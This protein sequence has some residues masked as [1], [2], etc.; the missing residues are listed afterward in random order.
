MTLVRMN[1]K[2]YS[3]H[4]EAESS[5]LEHQGIYKRLS[6][7]APVQDV[8]E[9]G[10]GAGLATQH[11]ATNRRV[12]SIDNNMH[13]IGS[14]KNLLEGAGIDANIIHADFFDLSP[15]DVAVIKDFSPKGIIG[16]FI[17]SHPDDM[18]KR[19]PSSTPMNEKSKKYRENIEDLIVS[20]KLCPHSVEWIHLASRGGVVE[21]SSAD[22]IFEETKKDYDT[23]VFSRHG[24][25]VVDVQVFEWNREGSS[26]MYINA[27]N[28]NLMPGRS[29][30]CITSILAK[31]I[32]T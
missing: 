2:S 14:A 13:L 1:E 15:Q 16:W 31:R 20:E 5:Q 24:F 19:T 27:P 22:F 8:L 9:V 6:E 18:D 10:C 28:P 12:L 30:Y 23:Y 3:E 17:G 4:W 32:G 25:E 21:G 11:L 26:F 7:I 29:S